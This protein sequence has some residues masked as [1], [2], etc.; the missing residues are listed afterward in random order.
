METDLDFFWK[1]SSRIEKA[2]TGKLKW[3]HTTSA[4]TAEQ[5]RFVT[6]ALQVC[7]MFSSRCGKNR[8]KKSEA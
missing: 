7:Q 6:R 3:K 4:Q 5:H 1:E 2:R 8:A